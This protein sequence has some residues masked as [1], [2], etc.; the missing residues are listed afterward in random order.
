MTG[1]HNYMIN[2]QVNLEGPS[3]VADLIDGTRR[4]W[5]TD[6][7]NHI[8]P[9]DVADKI[10]RIPISRECTMDVQVQKGELYG[11][12]SVKSAYKLLHEGTFILNYTQTDTRNLYKQLWQLQLPPKINLHLWKYFWGYIP[13]LSNFHFRKD[14][15]RFMLSQIWSECL[16][17]SPFV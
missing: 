15:I 9:G 17:D 13:T 7:I 16:N 11:E 1:S 4:E 8:F 2:Q 3:K 6:L 12:F 10:Q 5:R 14:S